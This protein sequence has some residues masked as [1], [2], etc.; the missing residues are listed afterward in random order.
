MRKLIWILAAVVV[1]VV[2]LFSFNLINLNVTGETELP[3]VD[4]SVEEGSLPEVEADTAD[5]DIG[6]ETEQV[7][8]PDVDVEVGTEETDVTVPTVDVEP[9]DQN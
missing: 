1:I 3:D 6:T 9:A 4:V 2:L 7:E 5:I 8:V